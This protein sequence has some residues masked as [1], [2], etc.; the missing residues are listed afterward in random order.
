M[1]KLKWILS[2]ALL[3]CAVAPLAANGKKD[4]EQAK[5]RISKGHT[6]GCNCDNRPP[7]RPKVWFWFNWK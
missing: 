3:F 4:K 2:I 5:E 1:F 6:P 7:K